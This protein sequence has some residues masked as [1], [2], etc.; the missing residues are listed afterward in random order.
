LARWF[1]AGT[2]VFRPARSGPACAACL[3]TYE[4]ANVTVRPFLETAASIEDV[5]TVVHVNSGERGKRKEKPTA[6]VWAIGRS[7]ITYGLV[8]A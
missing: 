6:V 4:P 2:H 7:G 3:A 1:A 8:L 5:C